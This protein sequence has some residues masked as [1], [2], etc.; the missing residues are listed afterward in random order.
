[1][2]DDPF[3]PRDPL[4]RPTQARSEPHQG[5][6]VVRIVRAQRHGLLQE[7]PGGLEV[8]EVLPAA[9]PQEGDAIGR[10]GMRSIAQQLEDTI[11][12]VVPGRGVRE[13][14]ELINVLL[15]ELLGVVA[16]DR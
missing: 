10:I 3:L 4:R 15:S 2:V 1:V 12:I 7:E 8:P 13:L 9:R 16:G 11:P 6:A 5:R 14:V